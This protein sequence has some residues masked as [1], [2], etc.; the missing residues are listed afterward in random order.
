MTKRVGD[1]LFE[2]EVRRALEAM[3]PAR[4]DV[5]IRFWS[6]TP[7]H[8]ASQI[9]LL[10]KEG[11]RVVADFLID[12]EVDPTLRITLKEQLLVLGRE[13]PYPQED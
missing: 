3:P 11:H 13:L 4:R 9:G 5:L 8:R 12:A 10:H 2:R 1:L 7:Q 6:S